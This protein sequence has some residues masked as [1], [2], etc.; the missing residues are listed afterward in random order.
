MP[1]FRGNQRWN[2]HLASRVSMSA[3]ALTLALALALTLWP[4]SSRAGVLMQAFYWDAPSSAEH[5]WWDGIAS[6]A[7]ELASSGFTALW[8]PPAL[9]GASGAVSNGYDPFDDYDL[10]SKNQRGTIATHWGTREQLQ[11]AVAIA[12]ANGLDVYEDMVLAQRDGDA[13][14][15]RYDYPTAQAPTG[16]R[17]SKTVADF[18]KASSGFG[19]QLNYANPRTRQ[20]LKDAGDWQMR[21]LGAQGVRIDYALGVPADFLSEYLSYGAFAGKFAVSELWNEDPS[22]LETFVRDKMEGKT[23]AFDFPLWGRLKDMANGKGRFDMRTLA[24]A[25]LIAR[26]PGMAVTFA[27]NHDTDRS[28]PTRENKRLSYAFILTSDG[29]PSV[30]WKDYYNYGMK[31]VIDPLVWIHENLAAGA[32]EYRWAD[33]NLLV[34]ERHGKSGLLVGINDNVTD[35]RSATVATGF[36]P[37]VALH[38]YTEQMPDLRTDRDG[39]LT[40]TV[41]A[42]SYVAYAPAGISGA[43]SSTAFRTTQDFDGAADLDIPPASSAGDTPVGRIYV[44]GGTTIRWTL[45]LADDRLKDGAALKLTI[46]DPS[47]RPRAAAATQESQGESQGVATAE[48]TGWYAFRIR[49]DGPG[50]RS[51]TVPFRLHVTYQAP[52]TL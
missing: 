19:R 35:A 3:S 29:Y 28:Y 23:H 10:G 17:F 43:P 36:G 47:E 8:F 49:A 27:E 24:T 18:T 40:L 38:D 5:R 22:V 50:T 25:G 14:D 39:Q 21:A 13:G 15:F 4:A 41:A 44:Q 34:Y 51:A 11:R 52:R 12:R 32:T 6:H 7:R 20:E 16:G 42:S 31:P 2:N 45:S 46:L 37:N 30:F 1:G 9:K 33:N 48:A 26:D